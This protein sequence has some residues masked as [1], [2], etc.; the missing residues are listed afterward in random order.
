MRVVVFSDVQANLPALQEA[1]ERIERAQPDLV[2]SNGDLVN[3]GPRSKEVL[4]LMRG[5]EQSSGWVGLRGNHED[6]VLRCGREAPKDDQDAALRGFTDWTVRQLATDAEHLKTWADNYCFHSP[7]RPRQWVHVTHGTPDDNRRGILKSTT[8]EILREHMPQEVALFI[9]AHTHRP[10][11]RRVDDVEI[12][13]VGSVG[14]PFDGDARGSYAELEFYGGRWHSRI[15]RFDYDR[16]QAERDFSETGF[17][18]QGGP[19]AQLIFH[20]WK[21]ARGFMPE[22]HAFWKQAVGSGKHD[23]SSAADAFIK[24]LADS[25]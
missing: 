11:I 19:M 17:L 6:Y 4:E 16:M 7:G 15:R 5:M 12:I 24:T 20:E 18:D 1:V 23:I 8:D 22:W 21:L 14:S 25:Y 2:I 3:R 13:N 10:L 9:T